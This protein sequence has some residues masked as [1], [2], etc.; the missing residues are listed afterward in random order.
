MGQNDPYVSF[1]RRQAT[2][3]GKKITSLHFVESNTQPPKI[4]MRTG[5]LRHFFFGLS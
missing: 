2:Q 1:L 3:K 4:Q 5:D